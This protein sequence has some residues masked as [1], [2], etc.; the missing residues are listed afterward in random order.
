MIPHTDRTRSRRAVA[1]AAMLAASAMFVVGSGQA[2][3]EPAVGHTALVPERPRLNVTRVLDGEV[4]DIEL[5]GNRVILAGTFTQLKDTDGTVITQKYLAAYDQNTGAMDRSFNPVIDRVVADVAVAPDASAIYAVGEFNTIDGVTK[6]KIARLTPGGDLVAGFTAQANNRVADVAAAANRVFVGGRFTDINGTMRQH[7]AALNPAT[8]AVD[9]TFDIPLTVG[10]GFLGEISTAGLD[11][12]ADGS[13]LLV[14]HSAALMAGQPRYGVGLITLGA[15]PSLSAWRTRLYENNLTNIEVVRITNAAIS[16]DGSYLVLTNS[17]GDKPPTNDTV[18]RFSTAVS[19]DVQ[20]AWV[21]R[22][23]DSVY[24]LAITEQAVYVGG[25]FQFQEAPG[26]PDPWPG[27]STT[28]YGWGP[29]GGAGVLAPAVVRREQLGAL[30]P[31]TGWAK[32]WNP[33]TDAYHGIVA[34]TAVPN[35][36]LVGGDMDRL[37]SVND[38]GKHGF[39]DFRNVPPAEDPQTSILNPINGQVLSTANPITLAGSATATV[40]VTKVNLDVRNDSAA[41]W[42]Q[43]DGSFSTTYFGFSPALAAPNAT[44]TTWSQTVNLPPGNYTISAKTVGTGAVKDPTRASTKIVVNPVDT[45]IPVIANIQPPSNTQTFPTNDVTVTG[46]VTDNRGVRQVDVEVINVDTG[47]YLQADGTT[48]SNFYSRAAAVENPDAFSTRWSI[49]VTV[50]NGR[51]RFTIKATDI[52]GNK[53]TESA[54]YLVFPNDQAP[55][56]SITSPAAN[57]VQAP[58]TLLISGSA[59]DDVGVRRIEVLIRNK[60][61]YQGVAANGSLGY[62]GYFSVPGV[63][64]GLT[65]VPFSYTSPALPP[66]SYDVV[67]RAVDMN[68][69]LSTEPTR[70]VTLQVPGDALPDTAITSPANGFQSFANLTLAMTGTATDATAVSGVKLRVRRNGTPNVYLQPDGTWQFNLALVNGTVTSPGAKSTTWSATF[71]LLSAGTYV[72]TAFAVDNAGQLDTT[73][74]APAT[75]TYL[76]YPGDADPTTVLLAPANGAT[77]GG[78]RIVANGTEADNGAVAGVEVLITNN[79]TGRGPRKDGTY[80]TSPAYLPGT[81]TNPG[82]PVSNW[83]YS[84]ITLPAGTYTVQVRAKDSLGKYDL[85]PAT[86]TVTVTA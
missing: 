33:G 56:I 25:H 3:A 35:G 23:F 62:A 58:G 60:Q 1:L 65:S 82:G 2:T 84:S 81:L 63:P 42:L 51:W 19:D 24:A 47:L 76:V 28:N 57:L 52:D 9:T 30:D 53:D 37:G 72:V 32:P 40:G 45:V 31:A 41:T 6:R 49:T 29:T 27:D 39:F 4:S 79:A 69:Q 55:V 15:T 36:L 73:P 21:S 12:S 20:A 18:I 48:S 46:D 70:T 7:L 78:G 14:A 38:L 80:G 68:Q 44:S 77:V 83:T 59:T 61:S 50:P 75:F 43:G 22:H 34:M 5:I 16:P 8:G 64:P 10:L 74:S 86:A 13:T 11:L 54:Q 66:G 67:V 85:T 26:A 71:P 17:G